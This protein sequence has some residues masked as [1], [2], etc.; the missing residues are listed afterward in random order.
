MLT[1]AIA[2]STAFLGVAVLLSLWRLV[3]GPAASD[4]ILAL[5]TLYLNAA[6]LLVVFGIR[7]A[8]TFYFEAVLLIA[9]LG[10]IATVAA[11]RFGERGAIID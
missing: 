6:G 4:R 9:V 7:T 8:S 5:D 11:A 2:L 1:H 10:F 3:V